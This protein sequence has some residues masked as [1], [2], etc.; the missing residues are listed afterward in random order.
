MR[1]GAAEAISDCY[2]LCEKNSHG[3]KINMNQWNQRKQ[4]YD[5]SS[6][7]QVENKNSS[8]V[9]R[10][11]D[12]AVWRCRAGTVKESWWIFILELEVVDTLNILLT[13]N[14]L[15][16]QD[17]KHQTSTILR[18]G[19]RESPIILFTIRLVKLPTVAWLTFN[20]Y[21]FE[22]QTISSPHWSSSASQRSYTRDN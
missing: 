4:K 5:R 20:Y 15:L 14:F 13:S 10:F 19:W 12:E 17:L 18:N 22:R 11:S 2:V 8:R 21:C 16:L 9:W 7:P 6:I 3:E 1:F